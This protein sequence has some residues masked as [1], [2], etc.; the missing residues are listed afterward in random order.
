VSRARLLFVLV[1]GL[2]SLAAAEPPAGGYSIAVGEADGLVLPSG[3]FPETCVDGPDGHVCL[4]GAYDSD[5]TGALT[6]AAALT[7]DDPPFMLE[8]AFVLEGQMA[9]STLAPKAVLEL[10]GMGSASIPD[11]NDPNDPNLP[12]LEFDVEG[13]GRMKCKLDLAALEDRLLCKGKV[14]LCVFDGDGV[15]RGCENVRLLLPLEFESVPFEIQL[16]LATSESGQV[17]GEGA[18]LI[19]AAPPLAYTAAGRHKPS[20]DVTNLKLT[21]S[22]PLLKTYVKLKKTVLAGGGAS[23]GVVLFKV[24]GQKGRVALPAATTFTGHGTCIRGAFCDVNQDTSQ[25]FTGR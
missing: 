18:V 11:P 24:A 25:L 8:A 14:R 20:S 17:S 16:D 5:A 3:A 4:A 21:G 15:K 19:D 1:L 12:P 13:T 2:A 22:D 9:G 23:G 10:E 6:G 7:L